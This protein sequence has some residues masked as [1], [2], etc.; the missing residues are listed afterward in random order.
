MIN[1]YLKKKSSY[2]RSHT[3]ITYEIMPNQV[4]SNNFKTVVEQINNIMD[5]NLYGDL[6]SEM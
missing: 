2:R 1:A 6:M 3:N 4:E 5:V